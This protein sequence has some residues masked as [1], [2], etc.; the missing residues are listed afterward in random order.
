MT[1]TFHRTAFSLG[2]LLASS[3]QA[4]DTKTLTDHEATCVYLGGDKGL[5][6]TRGRQQHEQRAVSPPRIAGMGRRSRR[7]RRCF[8]SPERSK[9]EHCCVR[10]W[11]NTAHS[12]F[13]PLTPWITA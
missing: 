1:K 11:R 2:Q 9:P 12:G 3:A 4:A 8:I 5:V 10:C 13:N 6:W 7:H